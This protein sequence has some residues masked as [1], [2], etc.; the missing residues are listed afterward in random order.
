MNKLDATYKRACM[1]TPRDKYY[2]ELFRT[3]TDYNNRNDSPFSNEKTQYEI[4]I[5][6]AEEEAED[7][8]IT[9]DAQ[10]ITVDNLSQRSNTQR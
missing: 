6:I 1:E 10:N 7:H 8:N 9:L 5:V 2:T 3:I 4:H